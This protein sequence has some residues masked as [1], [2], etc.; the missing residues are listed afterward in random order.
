MV[1]VENL[2]IVLV[3]NNE[4]AEDLV[5]VKDLVV[6]IVVADD[7]AVVKDLVFV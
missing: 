1:V 6:V 4:V 5:V 3:I 2:V 7:L